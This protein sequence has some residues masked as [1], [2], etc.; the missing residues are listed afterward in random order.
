MDS[1]QMTYWRSLSTARKTGWV[2]YF[3]IFS[4]FLPV[5]GTFIAIG[6]FSSEKNAWRIRQLEQRQRQP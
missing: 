3:A 4:L 2:A 6:Q 5:I 1:Q